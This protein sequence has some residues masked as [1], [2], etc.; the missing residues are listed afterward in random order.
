MGGEEGGKASHV[1]RGKGWDCLQQQ[2]EG[3]MVGNAKSQSQPTRRGSARSSRTGGRRSCRSLC[4]REWRG[5]FLLQLGDSVGRFYGRDEKRVVAPS[6]GQ[7]QIFGWIGLSHKELKGRQVSFAD[8]CFGQHG[9]VGQYL[10][11]K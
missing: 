9:I 3:G 7:I 4:G 5:R 2:V 6:H 10:F 11:F 1:A 8:P